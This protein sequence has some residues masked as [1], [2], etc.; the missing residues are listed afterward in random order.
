MNNQTFFTTVVTALIEQGRPAASK[1]G[2]L[3]RGTDGTKC[4]IGIIIPDEEYNA[5]PIEG[6]PVGTLIANANMW[7]TLVTLTEKVDVNLMA[8]MQ[9]AHDGTNGHFT[10]YGRVEL[11]DTTQTAAYE[12]PNWLENFK[13]RAKKIAEAWGL[14][15]GL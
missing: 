15:H 6:S 14:N 11:F 2:C 9:A 7:P 13:I 4:A 8:A 1:D 10:P 5:Y 12:D 3:Y